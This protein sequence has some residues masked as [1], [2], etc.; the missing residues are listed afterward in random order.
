[1]TR[2]AFIERSLRQI[3]GG[4][5]NDDSQID[6]DLVNSW[7][8]PAAALAAKT[9]Y[10]DSIKLDGVAY[11][12]GSFYTTFKGLAISQDESLIWK[13]E[14]PSIPLGLGNDEGVNTLQIKQNTANISLPLTWVN[15]MQKGYYQSMRPI[16]NKLLCYSEGKFVYVASTIL[17]SQY[18]AS[19][20]MV[21]AGDAT[22]LDSELNVPADYHNV[23][24]EYIKQQLVFE[25]SQVVDRANDG[26]D[27][28]PSA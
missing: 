2:R 3:Y 21:S 5:P 26:T 25:K 18:T 7:L 11:I 27:V 9:N 1:M 12:N 4:F 22:N 17:L 6:E 8:E 24:I 15:Q 14:L 10:A 16:P 13:I 28:N 19:V 23:M 20:T